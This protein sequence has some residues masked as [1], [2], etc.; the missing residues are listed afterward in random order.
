M[1]A[2]GYDIRA[3][4]NQPFIPRARRVEKFEFGAIATTDVCNLE[5]V[6]CH[7]NGPNATK[8]N[9]QLPVSLVRKVFDELPAGSK[10]FM[11]SGGDL[12]MD[13]DAEAHIAYAISR[14]LK[15]MIQSHGQLYSPEWLE[16][17]LA[18]GVREFWRSCDT[19]D[20]VQYAK[21][22]RGGEP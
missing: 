1:D 20:P 5:C 15:P 12:F 14:G 16:R 6:M 19:I 11:S 9:T 10:V 22:R 8:K 13:P 7:F 18:M 17:L 3:V 21:I 2:R 4:T